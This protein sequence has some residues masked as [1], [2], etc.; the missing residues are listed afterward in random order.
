MLLM[1]H[2][3]MEHI[4]DTLDLMITRSSDDFI[5]DSFVSDLIS[6]YIALISVVR[7]HK[8]PLLK[9]TISCRCFSAV[10]A[11]ELASNISRSPLVCN[12]A[13][14][15]VGLLLQYKSAVTTALAPM[16]TKTRIE[17]PSS[18]WFSREIAA[19]RCRK[20]E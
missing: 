8:P 18:P 12:P 9:K 7:A 3:L 15:I 2:T 16:K 5:Y 13:S 20:L 11:D 14:T 19:A 1:L 4:D 10:D 6:D 17:G